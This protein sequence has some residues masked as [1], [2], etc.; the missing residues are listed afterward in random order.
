MAIDNILYEA[1]AKSTTLVLTLPAVTAAELGLQT[2]I[3]FTG[4]G[5]DKWLDIDQTGDSATAQIGC[6]GNM[7]A[8]I[9]PSGSLVKGMIT[10]NPS[11]PT[12]PLIA[13][14]VAQ[15]YAIGKIVNCTLTVTNISV[16]STIQYTNFVLSKQYIGS[17]FA[18]Q[19]NDYEFSFYS[20]PPKYVDLAS[21]TNIA[22]AL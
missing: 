14:I 7:I 12:I 18:Q 20:Q 5:R 13:N 21:L 10:F 2:L 8:S 1:S 9:Q 3:V 19:L 4:A 15:Q 11:S 16:G 6:D 22:G 17:S